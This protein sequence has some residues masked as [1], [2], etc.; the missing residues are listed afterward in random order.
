M[1]SIEKLRNELENVMSELNEEDIEKYINS[2]CFTY[3]KALMKKD[4]KELEKVCES[5]KFLIYNY[6]ARFPQIETYITY[7]LVNSSNKIMSQV[8]EIDCNLW[9]PRETSLSSGN[10][11]SLTRVFDLSRHKFISFENMHNIAKL[12]SL[13]ENDEK[14]NDEMLDLIQNIY[15]SCVY[16]FEEVE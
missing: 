16:E 2:L 12:K 15:D 14:D 10:W 5:F 9:K 3:Y 1:T 6:M 8:F 13:I 4:C 7:C 11:S